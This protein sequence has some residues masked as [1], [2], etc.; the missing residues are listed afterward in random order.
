MKH[1]TAIQPLN[2]KDMSTFFLLFSPSQFPSPDL[3]VMSDIFFFFKEKLTIWKV[4]TVRIQYNCEKEHCDN[5]I[6]MICLYDT[7][8]SKCLVCTLM[9][10][11]LARFWNRVT[12]KC[13]SGWYGNRW[14]SSPSLCFTVSGVKCQ[15]VS[16]RTK[17]EGL[18]LV[19]H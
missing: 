4:A 3:D 17:G 19:H 14:H 15:P 16:R 18:L 6:Q 11:Q 13:R 7:L 12:E 8:P 10:R 9:C 1:I 5:A 2:H